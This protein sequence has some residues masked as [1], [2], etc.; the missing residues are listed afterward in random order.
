MQFRNRFTRDWIWILSVFNGNFLNSA[1]RDLVLVLASLVLVLET[2]DY[3]ETI[4]K[5]KILLNTFIIII[6]FIHFCDGQAINAAMFEIKET[7]SRTC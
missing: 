2:N 1:K 5:Q 6:F 3:D 7:K 4:K